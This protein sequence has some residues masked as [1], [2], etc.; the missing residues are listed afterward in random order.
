MP[1]ER[2][3][4]EDGFLSGLDLSFRPGLNVIIGARGTGKTSII[5]LLRFALGARNHTADSGPESLSHARSILE[6]G[7]VSVTLNTGPDQVL[8]S[9]AA[10]EDT[11]RQTGA[12]TAP[13]VFSQKE[14]ESIG[15]TDAGRLTL[16]DGFIA[17]RKEYRRRE[18]SI[19]AAVKSLQREI[20]T[21]AREADAL[22]EGLP[23]LPALRQQLADA[24]LRQQQQ[25]GG[26][27]ELAAK[28]EALATLT[29][30]QSARSVA[31]AALGRFVQ[32]VD[33]W[34]AALTST[35][36]FGSAEAVPS[37]RPDPLA[38]FR[39]RL[40]SVQRDTVTSLTNLHAL[41]ADVLAAMSAVVS[42]GMDVEGRAR[43]LRSEVN[44]L[45]EGAG[46]LS[47]E[48]SNLQGKIAELDAVNTVVRGRAEQIAE[49]RTRRDTLLRDLD[50]A[51]ESRFAARVTAADRINQDL[52][53][54]IM[55]RVDRYAQYNDYIRAIVEA[56]R[57]SNLKYNDLSAAITQALSPSELVKL[58][59]AKDFD[60]L[61][62]AVG[63][64]RDRAAKVS[65]VL[66]DAGLGEI[67][68]CDIEDDVRFMLLDGADYKDISQ[69]SA[70][71]RC[72]V[73]L[74]IVLQHDDRVLII[75]Q[76]EDHIDNAFIADTLI[77]ALRARA[78]Q[79]QLIVSTHNANI[80]V[81]GEASL[82]IEM[83]SDGRQGTV[84]V[85]QP[86]EHPDAVE[87]ITTVMEGGEAAFENRARFYKEHHA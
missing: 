65:G 30:E 38:P 41:R 75:D 26:S 33:R 1:I 32:L 2:I 23:G 70:G 21:R 60:A 17:D 14:I 80:P 55:V 28:N 44:V 72:T 12:F 48:V 54:R 16:L 85:C 56:L 46:A 63:I 49:M 34:I 67:A 31:E 36:D 81:L 10:H 69:L 50:Q 40:E 42:Q 61:A 51:R 57:G 53:P 77:K 37:D 3:Q 5:E 4:V 68:A 25:Q 83:V 45:V 11:A 9:R 18:E 39:D 86:L 20:E 19:I 66:A 27:A 74:P 43:T 64:A 59:E 78:S 71:Q 79:S 47:R 76:P 52:N 8:V 6:S 7:E 15:L 58:V 22:A 24:L 13:I 82:V 62:I 73:I 35:S 87:A 29:A 84:Q